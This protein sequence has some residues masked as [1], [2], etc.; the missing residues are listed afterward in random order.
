MNGIC[1]SCLETEEEGAVLWC[2]P[3]EMTVWLLSP[4]ASMSAGWRKALASSV[5]CP[6]GERGL[7]PHLRVAVWVGGVPGELELL[8]DQPAGS[9][10]DASMTGHSERSLPLE[11]RKSVNSR[12]IL[13][14]ILMITFVLAAAFGFPRFA[15][16]TALL[17]FGERLSST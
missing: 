8:L 1:V 16:I 3:P 10:G 13:P 17:H 4:R 7:P 14:L 12:V 2:W 9:L 15:N 6:L 11:D 5:A